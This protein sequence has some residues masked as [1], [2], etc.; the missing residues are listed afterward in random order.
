MK[1]IAIIE[2]VVIEQRVEFPVHNLYRSYRYHI[3]PREPGNR[4]LHDMEGEGMKAKCVIAA[5]LGPGRKPRNIGWY[6]RLR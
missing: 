2:T 5:I 6:R 1:Y 4:R 3:Q